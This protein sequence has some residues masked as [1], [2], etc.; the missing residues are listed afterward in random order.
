M[1]AGQQPLQFLP[2]LPQ[3]LDLAVDP[4]DLALQLPLD[5]AAGQFTGVVNR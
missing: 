4:A 2:E 5:V 1:P 3:L